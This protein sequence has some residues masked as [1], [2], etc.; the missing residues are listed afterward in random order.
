M[1]CNA[2]NAGILRYLAHR[3]HKT[4]SARIISVVRTSEID[5]ELRVK[6]ALAADPS[7]VSPGSRDSEVTRKPGFTAVSREELMNRGKL[8]ILHD[9]R[10]DRVTI[11]SCRHSER[12]FDCSLA[13]IVSRREFNIVCIL[14]DRPGHALVREHWAGIDMNCETC[15]T[16]EVRGRDAGQST[17]G[18]GGLP[19]D[20]V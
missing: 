6:D 19:V 5:T 14:K 18:T 1:Y 15:V 17:C 12:L 16:V 3:P 7:L 20:R 13:C 8:R 9:N 2:V 11:V 4:C 10:F